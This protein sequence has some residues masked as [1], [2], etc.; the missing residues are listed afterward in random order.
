MTDNDSL[1]LDLIVLMLIE[2]L[3]DKKKAGAAI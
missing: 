1:V 2:H 3:I